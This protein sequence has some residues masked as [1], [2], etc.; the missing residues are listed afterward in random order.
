MK[1]TLTLLFAALV[2]VAASQV[3]LD[4]TVFLSDE[5]GNPSG[6]VPVAFSVEA[7][8]AVYTENANT[9]EAGEAVVSIEL[10]NG[11]MQ[12]MLNASYMNCDSVEVAMNGSFSVNALGGLSDVYLTGIY[13]GGGTGGEDCNMELDGGLTVLGSWM[14]MVSGAPEDAVYDWSIDGA[15]MSNGNSPEF[16][17]QFDGESVWTV[18]VY[19]TSGSCEP[20]TD[21]YVVDTTNP[22]GGGEC[23][24]TF[25]V[26]QS[27][28]E[29]GNEIP[30]SLDVIVP[31]LEGQPTYFWDFGDEGTSTEASPTHTYEGN[32]PYMLC[33]TA[34]WGLNTICTATYCDSVS[35]DENGM[36]N[37]MDGF[38]INVNPQ[39]GVNSVEGADVAPSLNMFPNPVA[40][41]QV[42]RW[43]AACSV[44]QWV[45]VYTSTGQ[46]HARLTVKEDQTVSTSGWA[47]GMYWLQWACTGGETRTGRL[48][49]Q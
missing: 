5:A 34:T 31:E 38:T 29:A 19:V 18:C 28:D 41:G 45:I 17:W 25:E 44:D 30:G 35:V 26:I 13:C 23:E 1:S 20:W 10:P 15:T 8:G 11:T 32:G 12:G 42:I 6:G 33:L 21:C 36:I 16:G 39:G 40:S 43:N 7:A 49:V 48:I 9:N 27:V 2:S 46:L 3:S 37:F 14:F 24:L 4:A 22:T 47:P